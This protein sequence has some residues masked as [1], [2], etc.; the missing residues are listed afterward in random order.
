MDVPAP[1]LRLPPEITERTAAFLRVEY[2]NSDADEETSIETDPATTMSASE[3][4]MYDFRAFRLT[5]KDIYLKTFRL[6]GRRYFSTV[7]VRFTRVSLD[8]LRDLANYKNSFGLTLLEF[9]SHLCVDASLAARERNR[10]PTFSF[11]RR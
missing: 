9:P 7:S 11:R 4:S 6:F 1:L 8:R 3:K 10:S 2:S 5:C